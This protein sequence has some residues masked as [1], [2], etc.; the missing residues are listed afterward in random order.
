MWIPSLN[1]LIN[2]AI[3]FSDSHIVGTWLNTIIGPKQTRFSKS[4][5]LLNLDAASN[6]L[7]EDWDLL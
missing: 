5:K 2:G 4:S 1:C 6:G 7:H 3:I